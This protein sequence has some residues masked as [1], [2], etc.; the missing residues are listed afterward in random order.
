M[1]IVIDPAALEAISRDLLRHDLA[2]STAVATVFAPDTGGTSGLSSDAI[3]ALLDRARAVADGVH[4]LSD[5]LD[6]TVADAL[7]TDGSVSGTFHSVGT[8]VAS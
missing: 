6:A 3:A 8:G 5:G 4:Q 1:S 7:A 2:I